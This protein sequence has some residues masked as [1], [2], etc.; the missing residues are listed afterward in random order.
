MSRQ[1]GLVGEA[2]PQ[3]EFFMSQRNTSLATRLGLAALLSIG[4]AGAAFAGDIS[5]SDAAQ[6][7]IGDT[8][9]AIVGKLGDPV[10]AHGYV[11][12]PGSTAYYKLAGGTLGHEPVL[13]IQFDQQQRVVHTQVAEAAFFGLNSFE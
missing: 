12:A 9:Q 13:V 10:K 4:A 8:E 6:V 11:M 2:P 3:Q 7:R 1:A 5:A